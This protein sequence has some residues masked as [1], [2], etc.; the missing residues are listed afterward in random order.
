MRRPL[1]VIV[2]VAVSAGLLALVG[3]RLDWREALAALARVRATTLLACTALALVGYGGR[4][5]R[6]AYLLRHAGVAVSRREAYRLTLVGIFY[7]LVTPGRVGELARALHLEAPG[8]RTLP[9]VVW[10]RFA[11]VLLLELLSIPAFTVLA[12]GGSGAPR[13][14]P[15][16]LLWAY[17][18]IVG[19]TAGAM[20][21]MDSPRLLA[22][23]ERRIPR[24]AGRLEAWRAGATGMLRSR[25]FARGLVAGLF[26]YALNFAGASLLLDAL[27]PGHPG[28]LVLMFPVIIL[29]GNLPI[30]FGGL[31]LR[32]QVSAMAFARLGAPAAVGPVFSL[33][34]F[35]VISVVPALLGLATV[36]T[37]WGGRAVT[38]P[39]RAHGAT[40]GRGSDA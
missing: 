22:W 40:P 33:L 26:F 9:S 34:W 29:L 25:A 16:P 15:G 28:A 1:A 21:A 19:L 14:G 13:G 31:G 38:L 10:D 32:E 35:L 24:A 3:A 5:L 8:E 18:A 39:S 37:R 12:L 4:A 6:W 2:R 20:I 36:H 27:A 30:A 11:D 17:L 7:G 23:L